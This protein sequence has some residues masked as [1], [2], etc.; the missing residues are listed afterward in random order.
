MQWEHAKRLVQEYVYQ[1]HSMLVEGVVLPNNPEI[2]EETYAWQA[3]NDREIFE[4]WCVCEFLAEKLK[5]KGE[6]TIEY[7]LAHWWGRTTTGQQIAADETI[8]EIAEELY[9]KDI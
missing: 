3:T 4:W 1:N 6:H 7:G 9:A 8:Q 2:A 5:G